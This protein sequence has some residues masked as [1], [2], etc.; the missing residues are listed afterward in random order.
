MCTEPEPKSENPPSPRVERGEAPEPGVRF[1]CP[2]CPQELAADA[3]ALD[4][5]TGA[6]RTCGR[7]G[8]LCHVA[9]GL[10][11]KPEAADRT[12]RGAVLVPS[13]G[14]RDWLHA[15]PEFV[16]ADAALYARYGLWA[17]CRGCRCRRLAPGSLEVRPLRCR[18]CGS[19]DLLAL[20]VRIPEDVRAAL[21]ARG[22]SAAG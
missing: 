20:V 3:Q 18:A 22:E 7:C 16:R 11:R 1:R 10:D 17:F 12:V 6:F 15:H 9:P 19:P 2:A 4:S 5:V 13:V 14:F 8:Q 21:Q